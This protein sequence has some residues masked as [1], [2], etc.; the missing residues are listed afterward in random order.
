MPNGSSKSRTYRRRLYAASTLGWTGALALAG[1]L[2]A[3]L[4]GSDLGQPVAGFGLALAM[5]ATEV[6]PS[7]ELPWW[8]RAGLALLAAL[9]ALI[10]TGVLSF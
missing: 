6:D 5:A 2:V 3:M 8:V 10:G 7:T 1:G 9:G 4:L